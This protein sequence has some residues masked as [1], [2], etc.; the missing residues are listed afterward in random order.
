MIRHLTIVALL[1]ATGCTTVSSSTTNREPQVS[2]SGAE[3]SAANPIKDFALRGAFSKQLER[4]K[5]KG[6]ATDGKILNKQLN[7]RQFCQIELPKPRT[8]NL[9]TAEV[10][11]NCMPSTLI[12]GHLY[13]CGRCSKWHSNVASGFAVAADV[14]ATN[15]HVLENDKAACFGVMTADG[16]VYPVIEAKQGYCLWLKQFNWS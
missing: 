14:I 1:A 15:H 13:K 10:F 11:R 6:L 8:G 7:E 3:V 5:E 2:A 12:V 9:N 16:T 4:H